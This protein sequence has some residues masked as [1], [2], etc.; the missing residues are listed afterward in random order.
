MTNTFPETIPFLP[1]DF[2]LNLSIKVKLWEKYQRLD[3][4]T[5]TDVCDYLKEHLCRL[6]MK[7]ANPLAQQA[8]NFNEIFV[9]DFLNARLPS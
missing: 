7:Y 8:V 5:G 3:S 2:P 4:L 1:K 9:D 6:A